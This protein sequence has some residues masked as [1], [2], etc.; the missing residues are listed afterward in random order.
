MSNPVIL[1]GHQTLLSTGNSSVV[2]RAVKVWTDAKG[3]WTTIQFASTPLGQE[4]WELYSQGYQR[5]VS[6]GFIPK[7]WRDD[8]DE[9]GKK[10]RVYTKCELLEIS[11]VSIPSNQSALARSKS[12]KKLMFVQAKRDE[13]ILAEAIERD[14]TSKGRDFEAEA[15][16]F[17]EM[18]L[19]GDLEGGIINSNET[20]YSSLVRR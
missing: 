1:T 20:D 13:R 10:V 15:E 3:L 8:V 9:M 14:F 6:I 19:R 16:E 5:A 12:N 17:A 18:L 11:L 7:K 2:G 4:Y